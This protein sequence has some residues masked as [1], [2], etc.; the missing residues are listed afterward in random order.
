MPITD[1]VTV[2]RDFDHARIVLSGD[3]DI[4]ES[5][6]LDELAT[7]LFSE[8]TATVEV[9]MESVT[10]LG[11]RA[12]AALLHVRTEVARHSGA[13]MR[14]SRFNEQVRRIFELTGVLEMLAL[15]PALAEPALAETRM[16]EVA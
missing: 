5:D 14:I 11:S 12:L 9:D 10:F 4:A 1:R 7:S 8:L 15:G 6:A 16:S 3:L 2:H 13:E